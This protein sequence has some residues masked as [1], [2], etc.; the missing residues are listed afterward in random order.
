[1]LIDVLANIKYFVPF[2][3]IQSQSRKSSHNLTKTFFGFVQKGQLRRS[4]WQTTPYLRRRRYLHKTST[5]ASLSELHFWYENTGWPKSRHVLVRFLAH[6]KSQSQLRMSR[7]TGRLTT[8]ILCLP[9]FSE[10]FSGMDLFLQQ[11][12]NTKRLTVLLG[13]K[14]LQRKPSDLQVKVMTSIVLVTKQ[15]L[16]KHQEMQDNKHNRN[17]QGRHC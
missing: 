15:N 7:A 2:V 11:F 4:L 5:K 17:S 12:L 6:S 10:V 3:K 1:M 13:T 9:W 14:L 8:T 16:C